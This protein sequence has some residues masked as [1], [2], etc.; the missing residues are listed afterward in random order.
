MAAQTHV[1]IDSGRSVVRDDV[2][3]GDDGSDGRRRW[4]VLLRQCRGGRSDGVH[5][6]T[7]DNGAMSID[8]LPTRGMGIWRV[9]RG[10]KTLGWQAPVREPVNPAFVPLME[11]GGLGWLDGFNELLC[12][13]GLE[14]NG[15]PEF[16][17]AGRLLRPLHGRIANTPAHRVELV[18]DEDA[19]L[20]TLRG[21]V[22][23]SRFHFQSL[24]LTASISTA[25]GSNE[26][27]W[28]DDVENIGGR[29]ATLQMLYHFNIG[30]PLL[31][32]GARISA[33][34]GTAAPL[35][36]V[37]AK[38]GLEAWNIMPPSRPGSA[39]QVYVFDLAAEESG[40]T[41]VLISGLTNEEAV[42]LRFNKR[43]LPCFTVWRNTP[44]ES[45]GYVLGIEPG[46]NYPNPR[47]FEQQHGRVVSLK[48]GEK[49]HAAV[50]AIWYADAES[51][52][53][54]EKAIAAL[55]GNRRPELSSQPRGDWSK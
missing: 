11:P 44:P 38:E 36:Q 13:C 27:S 29:D 22:D 52:E 32:A 53:Q 6:A 10:D 23:E 43:T 21:V 2:M 16:D 24:R 33:P 41:R 28:S 45:D 46:T 5:V 51:I 25:M 31:R 54:E 15:P 47:T 8:V 39:E 55:Q 26:F 37:A 30:Q 40:E 7:L 49:W 14:S 17:E 35:T 34:I 3:F 1:L 50:A 48:P 19:G 18:V 12:R 20:L 4:K 42:G 9:N